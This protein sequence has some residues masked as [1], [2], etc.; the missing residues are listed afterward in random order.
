M[1]LLTPCRSGP[2]SIYTVTGTV[3]FIK[4]GR[5]LHTIFPT[6]RSWCVDGETKFVLRIRPDSYYRIELP[7][8]SMEDREIAEDLKRVFARV[9]Q[10][11]LTPCPFK[12][13]FTIEIPESPKTPAQK[14]P[15]KPRNQS[16]SAS[17]HPSTPMVGL[18]ERSRSASTVDEIGAQN[19]FQSFEKISHTSS[20]EIDSDQVSFNSGAIAR[21]VKLH[22]ARAVTAPTQLSFYTASSSEITLES[23][24]SD[25]DAASVSSSADSFHSFRSF[26]SPQSLLPPS[27]PYSNPPSPLHN[28]EFDLRTDVTQSCQHKRDESELT[29]TAEMFESINNIKTC[30]QS[31]V[32][33]PF[34]PILPRSPALT[35]DATSQSSDASPAVFTPSPV[36]TIRRRHNQSQ[37]RDRSPLPS[38]ANL[39]SPRHRVSGHH[40]TTAILQKTCSILLGPPVQLVA[41]MLN[42]AAKIANGAFGHSSN[43]YY[44]TISIPC[45]WELS[46][47]EDG[48]DIWGEDDYGISL[49]VL[50]SSSAQIPRDRGESW[51]ID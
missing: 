35:S 30:S 45:T 38:P 16:M 18:A 31:D 43:D 11:E 37:P 4:S 46:D 5:L 42:V 25:L 1:L 20:H 44:G 34:T 27:P 10:Y 26:H 19:N 17:G 23:H 21:P 3:S 9:S 48:K 36:I 29:V 15:W 41:L 47:D 24:I 2:F 28:E 32:E 33:Q 22:G 7:N 49:G 12:R 51:E 50:S 8:T 14:R 40:L 6:S 39:Y 13:G